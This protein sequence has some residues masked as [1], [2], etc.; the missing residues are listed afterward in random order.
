[1]ASRFSHPYAQ[2]IERILLD[3]VR[4]GGTV[5]SMGVL[6]GL[7]MGLM[8]EDDEDAPFQPVNRAIIDAT[9]GNP[10]GRLDRVKAVGHKVLD[11]A[12]KA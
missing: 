4:D 7:L 2:Q 12:L 6:Y 8:R 3:E 9:D 11:R 5:R 1:M 10:A